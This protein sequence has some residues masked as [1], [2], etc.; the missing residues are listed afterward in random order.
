MV[1]GCV[2]MNCALETQFSVVSFALKHRAMTDRN[3]Q[4]ELLSRTGGGLYWGISDGG[5]LAWLNGQNL[6][7]QPNSRRSSQCCVHPGHLA[8]VDFG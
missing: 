5:P 8:T 7:L 3:K 6:T 4:Q 1:I 2:A